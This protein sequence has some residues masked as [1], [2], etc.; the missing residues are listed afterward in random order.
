MKTTGWHYT[1]KPEYRRR[2]VYES[3]D[4]RRSNY[5]RYLEAAKKMTAVANVSQNSNVRQ[6]AKADAD[7]FYSKVRQLNKKRKSIKKQKVVLSKKTEDKRFDDWSEQYN[8][9]WGGK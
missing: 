5:K 4:K 9:A 7:Y 6:T 8:K 3:T 2:L 1:Q